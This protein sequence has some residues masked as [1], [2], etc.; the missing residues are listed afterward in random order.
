MYLPKCKV[1]HV[2]VKVGFI[3]LLDSFVVVSENVHAQPKRGFLKIPSMKQGGSKAKS[4]K[5][6]KLEF[7]WDGREGYGYFLENTVENISPKL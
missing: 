2:Y 5:D 6:P 4:F 7:L 1:Y 3:Y